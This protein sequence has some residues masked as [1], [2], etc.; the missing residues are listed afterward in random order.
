LEDKYFNPEEIENICSE[1]SA[2]IDTYKYLS[3][4]C[5]NPEHPDFK[6][7]T[8][9]LKTA[10]SDLKNCLGDYESAYSYYKPIFG[11]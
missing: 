9:E 5:T 11:F 6:Y 1:I 4:I 8:P 7:I 10:F 3:S 2:I